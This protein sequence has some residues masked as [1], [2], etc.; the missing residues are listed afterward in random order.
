MLM[1]EEVKLQS[2]QVHVN[3]AISKHGWTHK[4]NIN[5]KKKLIYKKK[6]KKTKDKNN[7]IYIF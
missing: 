7:L 1:Q 3:L 5:N 2:V 4:Y 6:I